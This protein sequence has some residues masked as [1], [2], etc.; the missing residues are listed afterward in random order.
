MA[1]ITLTGSRIPSQVHLLSHFLVLP[2]LQRSLAEKYQR[3][4]SVP[5]DGLSSRSSSP[6]K[7][8][9]LSG[10]WDDS[11]L[12]A[13]NSNPESIVED[14]DIEYDEGGIK[15][16]N[17][18]LEEEKFKM[19]KLVEENVKLQVELIKRNTEKRETIKRLKNRVTRLVSENNALQHHRL[20]YYDH[21]KQP[22]E[23][24]SPRRK[25]I[26]IDKFFGGCFRS[27]LV[28]SRKGFGNRD[29]MEEPS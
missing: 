17:A 6:S 21:N 26:L 5:Q 3:L 23:V 2:I 15:P 19:S 1:P 18:W 10:S 12:E 7:G 16:E 13:I 24:S 9:Q 28:R 11:Q 20:S 25:T 29:G 14:A 8:K 22:V 27:R 4:R